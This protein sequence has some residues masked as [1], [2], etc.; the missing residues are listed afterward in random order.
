MKL[1]SYFVGSLIITVLFGGIGISVLLNSWSTE[2]DKIPAVIK[3]GEFTGEYDPSDIRGSYSFEDIHKSFDVPVETLGRAFGISGVANLD[4]FRCKDLEGIYE[5]VSVEGREIG[6][7]SV[8]LFVALY[9]GIPYVSEPSTALPLQAVDQLRQSVE[10]TEE[11][12]K[13]LDGIKVDI[14]GYKTGAESTADKLHET[15]ETD[16]EEIAVKG[17]TTFNDLLEWGV[18]RSEIE[19]AL[20]MQMGT[21]G[22]TVRDYCQKNDIEFFEIKTKLQEK[23]DTLLQK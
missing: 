15:E 20:G 3:S 4:E 7:D 18:T 17:K 5:G 10:L 14:S 13:Y 22:E 9:K 1:K 16:M 21:P 6:T 23:I 12:V 8:R 11:Q 19:S 2:S